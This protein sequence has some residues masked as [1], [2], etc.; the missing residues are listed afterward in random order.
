MNNK[1][2]RDFCALP[3]LLVPRFGHSCA[4]DQVTLTRTLHPCRGKAHVVSD[5]FQRDHLLF[6]TYNLGVSWGIQPTLGYPDPYVPMR[7]RRLQ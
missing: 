7:M 5:G 6:G 4:V 2:S 1:I 3:R